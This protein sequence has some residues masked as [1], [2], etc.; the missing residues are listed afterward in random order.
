MRDRK[1]GKELGKKEDRG[2]RGQGKEGN[3]R[4]KVMRSVGSG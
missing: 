2:K 3:V 1:K 4:S